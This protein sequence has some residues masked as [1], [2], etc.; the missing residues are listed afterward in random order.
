[1]RKVFVCTPY[2]GDIEKNLE[3][4]KSIARVAAICD[5]VPVVPHLLFPQFLDDSNPQER[6]LG[7]RLGADMLRKCDEMW[8]L[9]GKLSRGMQ[10][11]LD[12]AKELKLPIRL[13]DVNCNRISSATLSIDDRIDDDFRLALKGANLA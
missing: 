9:V 6:I 3:V 2:R 13:I 4:A 12:L 1:M 11:E 7:L 8:L 10:Y 5:Y